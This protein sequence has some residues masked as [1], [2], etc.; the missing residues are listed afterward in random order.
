MSASDEIRAAVLAWPDT[1]EAP[2]RFGAVEFLLGK[3]EIGHLHGD[4]LLDV[5][6]P[7]AVHDELIAA[8]LATPHHVLPDSGWVSFRIR[9]AEDVEKAIAL[10]RRSYDL[11]SEQRARRSAQ[12]EAVKSAVEGQ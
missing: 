10:L 5:P 2:H 7:R 9:R 12:N 3:R 11:V 6:F 4:F 1:S 8:G